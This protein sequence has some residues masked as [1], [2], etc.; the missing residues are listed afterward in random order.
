MKINRFATAMLFAIIISACTDSSPTGP[1]TSSDSNNNPS[2]GSNGATDI[3][4]QV[5][6]AQCNYE[7]ESC[8]IDTPYDG[9]G[10][11]KGAILS[12]DGEQVLGMMDIIG[13]VNNGKINLELRTPEEEFQDNFVQFRLYNND[14]Y[15]GWLLLMAANYLS[16]DN[17]LI[18]LYFYYPEDYEYKDT[19]YAESHDLMFIDDIDVKKGWNLIYEKNEH[20]DMNGKDVYTVIKMSNPANILNGIELKWVLLSP[21]MH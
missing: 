20:R 15:I 6:H 14:E 4:S 13:T 5:Y 19:Y 7:D 1:G 11:I 18:G 10:V 3:N 17:D 12:D 21:E 9:S 16:H 8:S 2:S